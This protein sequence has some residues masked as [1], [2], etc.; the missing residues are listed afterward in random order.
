MSNSNY[1]NSILTRIFLKFRIVQV[2]LSSRFVPKPTPRVLYFKRKTKA[3]YDRLGYWKHFSMSPLTQQFFFFFTFTTV[4]S[5]IAVGRFAW[6]KS[7]HERV[8]TTR[9]RT[10]IAII[11]RSGAPEEN[12]RKRVR[13]KPS[14]RPVILCTRQHE[15][16]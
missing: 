1:T 5:P 13:C 9:T 14:Y 4:F 6:T 11:I 16:N 10:I 15:S 8:L 12:R 7:V 2:P 3:A